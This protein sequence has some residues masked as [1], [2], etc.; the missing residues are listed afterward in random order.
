[1]ASITAPPRRRSLIGAVLAA[2]RPG[3]VSQLAAKVREHVVTVAALTAIDVGAFHVP[4]GWG[5]FCGLVVTGGSLLVA[6]FAV[7]GR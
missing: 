2:H 5:M 4:G 6:D 3:R 7:T 1:L